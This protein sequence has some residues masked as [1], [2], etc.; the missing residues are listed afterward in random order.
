MKAYEDVLE[1][2]STKWA[3]WYIIPANHNWFR[4]V[5]VS[6]IIVKTLEQMYMKYPEAATDSKSSNIT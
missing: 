6:T 2:T 4:D 1:K 3:P 5:L